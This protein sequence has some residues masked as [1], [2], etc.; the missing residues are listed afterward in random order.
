MFKNYLKIALRALAVNRLYAAINI[1]GLA[2]GLTIFLFGGMIAGY[3]N[4]HDAAWQDKERIYYVGSLLS[5]QANIGIK[6]MD[7]TYSA[8]GPLFKE[9]IPEVEYMAR[10]IRRTYLASAGDKHFNENVWF[11]DAELF[12]I[13]SFTYLQ[14]DSS[15]RDDPEGVVLTRAQAEKM[16]GRVDVRGEMIQLNHEH[17]F[18]VQAVIEDLPLDTHFQSNMIMGNPFNILFSLKAL[19]RIADWEANY[20]N[21]SAGN[22]VYLKLTRCPW[23]NSAAS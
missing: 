15:A 9:G 14:G 11:T 17:E 10:T 16:F 6:Q 23:M 8:L 7:T 20:H 18:R 3:E 1:F 2:I 5:P 19:E 13:F 12:R 21:T 4:S 22:Y